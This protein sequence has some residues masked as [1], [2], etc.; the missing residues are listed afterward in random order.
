MD[1][2]LSSNEVAN[3][4]RYKELEGMLTPLVPERFESDCGDKRNL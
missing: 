4:R 3:R 1:D 2:R